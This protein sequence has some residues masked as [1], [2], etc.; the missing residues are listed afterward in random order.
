[1]R[2]L[3]VI[4]R[5]NV[6]G[7]ATYLSN[8][9]TGLQN[10]GVVNQLAMG[11]V[12]PG[13]A[14]DAVVS[15]LPIRRIEHLS[16]E[17]SL[18]ADHAAYRELKRAVAE[19]KPD[20]IH[21]HTFKAGL[22]MRLGKKSVPIIHSFHGHHLYD[23]EFGAGKRAVL[24]VI[25]RRLAKRSDAIVTI[26]TKVRDELLAQGIGNADQYTAIAPG[27]VALE[28]RDRLAV[29]NRLGISKD[30]LVVMWLGR[31]TEV[32][33]PDRVVEIAR[34]IPNA[35]FVLAG[36]GELL[37]KSRVGAPSN[38]VFV[39]FEDKNDMWA[40]A[41]IGLCTSDSEGMPL[42]L[43]EA[44]MAGVPVVSTDVGSV[45]EIVSDGESGFVAPRDSAALAERIKKLLESPQLRAE[46]GERS[47]S[48]A[49]ELFS[50][51]TMVDAHLALYRKVL[52]RR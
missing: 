2:V 11:H 44:Q 28:R 14:E 33:R 40:I 35:V 39:G 5:M 7:T 34:S 31:F 10:Q 36:G 1:M 43:I 21:S 32:K 22:L 6:G 3:H 15:T 50:A 26:G 9:I 30:A 49:S 45:A 46:M 13:E 18:S 16:R 47:R 25:E 20:L 4:A 41:D 42:S 24:N 37:E 51:K 27:I 38:V 29:R 48:R 23:P 19:F 17:I 12:P 52:A 8:L